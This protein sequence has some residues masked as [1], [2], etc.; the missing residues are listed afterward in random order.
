MFLEVSLTSSTPSGKIWSCTLY[1]TRPFSKSTPHRY[2]HPPNELTF[3][4]ILRLDL[5]EL[6]QEIKKNGQQERQAADE[7]KGTFETD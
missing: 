6:D 5:D 7:G 3:I 4:A 1:S 2:Y